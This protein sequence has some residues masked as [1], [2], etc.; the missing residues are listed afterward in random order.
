VTSRAPAVEPYLRGCAWPASEW[1]AYPRCDPGPGGARLPA[2]T[3]AQ[4]AL[5]VGVRLEFTGEAEAVELDYRT[6]TAELGVRGA[7]AGTT[8]ELY[9]GA[10]RV[11]E[12]RAQ[13]GEATVRLAAGRGPARGIVYL[14]EGM[15][16][17]VLAIRAIG[18]ALAPAAAQPRWLCYG[19]SIAEGWLASTPAGAWPARAGR[20]CELDVVNL[21]Y[22][23]GARGEIASAEELAALPADVISIAHGTNCWGRTPHDAALF[24]AGLAAFLRIVR[25]QHPALPI[26][27]VSPVLREQAEYTCNRLGAT[28]ADLRGAFEAV[29]HERIRAGDERLSLVEGLPLL[30]PERFPDGIHPDDE[31]HALLSA[32]IGPVIRGACERAAREDSR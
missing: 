24:G 2:D 16:P 25:Q 22:A 14:P 12:A 26:V 10:Q 17:E 31:G 28:L 29:V 21:G 5:P 32:S 11:S 3:R 8:F 6:A 9:R 27:A 15:R 19:D 30:G 23:G 13:L 7:G 18:G 20:E 4:A 1:A